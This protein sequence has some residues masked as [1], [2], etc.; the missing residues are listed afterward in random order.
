MLIIPSGSYK[1]DVV[2]APLL[3]YVK[4]ETNLNYAKILSIVGTRRATAYGRKQV[5]TIVQDSHRYE[6]LAIIS[7]LAYGIDIE[8]HKA[9]LDCGIPT[10]AVLGSG[11]DNVYPSAHRPIADQILAQGGALVTEY[12]HY[13]HPD[14]AHFPSRNRIIAG[15]SDGVIVV[16][17]AVKGGALLTAKIAH[18]YNKT[19]FAVPGNLTSKYSEGTNK[20]INENL[21]ILYMNTKNL[22]YHLNWDSEVVAAELQPT[23]DLENFSPDNQ[24]IL[25]LLQER[26]S[27]ALNEIVEWTELEVN[28]ITNLLF[29]LEMEGMVVYEGGMCRLKSM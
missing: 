28:H 16:E 6:D 4:G 26:E 17:S 7:G 18:S 21:A 24:L 11:L 2:D 22:D 13:K 23:L 14:R 5:R 10:V 8:A 3:L 15:L 25:K 20:F 19:V 29:E 12:P 27:C 9:C 1:K